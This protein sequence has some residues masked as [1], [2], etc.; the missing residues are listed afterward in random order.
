[1]KRVNLIRKFRLSVM[2]I[3]L[4]SVCMQT[5]AEQNDP[6]KQ[7]DLFE[8]SLE[9]LMN[10]EVTTA[11]KYKQSVSEAP[12]SVTVITD[13]D[14]RQLGYRTFLDI[15]ASVPGFYKTYDRNY[16]YL[17]VRGFGRPGD[18]NSRVLLLIDGHRINENVSDALGTIS[19]FYLDVDLIKRIEVVRGPGSALYGSNALF[20]VINVFTKNGEDYDGLEL[21]QEFASQSA[22]R[23]RVTYGKAF[24]NGLELLSSGSYYDRDGER[25]DFPDLGGSADNDDEGSKSFMFKASY[26]DFSFIA[27][28]SENEKGIP[29][30]P[31]GTVLGNSG[32]RTWDTSTVL[33]LNYQHDFDDDFTIAGKLS[34]NEYNYDGD[35]VYDDGGLYTNRDEWKGRWFIGDLQFTKRF[36]DVHTLVFGAESQYNMRQDQKNW[37]PG[38]TPYLDDSQHSKSW[39]VYIQDEWHLL[40][41]LIL[42]AGIRHDYYDSFGF[43]TNPR[44]AAI[45]KHSDDTVFK[46][47]F[48]T[49]F[50]APSAYELYYNDGGDYQIAN[51][52]L[53]PETIESYELILEQRINKNINFSISGY[54]N[55]IDDL[56]D[57]RDA[58]G[59]DQFQNVDE[60][61][62]KGVDLVL[63]GRWKNGIRS[64]LSYSYV[65][66]RD[67]STKETLA[68][69][70]ENMVVFNLIYP[71]IQEQLFAGF[72]AKWNS[73]RKTLA[74]DKTD[75]A[76]VANLTLT[77]ENILKSLDV[78]VGIYNLFDEEYGHPAFS[79]HA[80]MDIIEQDGRTVGVK[81]SYQF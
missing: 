55:I 28:H 41:N 4:L 73:E 16:G 29:T 17:G 67:K 81:L 37:D 53:D 12:S 43:T 52:N 79:E 14:I 76:V 5:F 49:A 77:Y 71:L 2:L 20:A 62:A 39:G 21:S 10:V 59:V 32:T 15:I 31:W 47:I 64:S 38:Y 44:I 40:D 65:R 8:M 61:T 23:S 54:Y 6:N 66:T 46:F 69:S 27:T 56:I 63:D 18:Y 70:P 78:Q 80:P 48:G 34:Y 11:S 19:D 1:M 50:R 22:Q 9:E 25:L 35:Y 45:Y 75:D 30:A 42:N 26:S 57:V 51:P 58:G 72:E 74:D 68:N 7:D 36:A 24:E 3:I 60:V 33:G 13:E